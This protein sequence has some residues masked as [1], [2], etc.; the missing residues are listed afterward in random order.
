MPTTIETARAKIV[1]SS[2]EFFEL[3]HAPKPFVAG[4]SYIPV[5]VK[6]MDADATLRLQVRNVGNT[7]RWDI[8]AN[9][10]ALVTEEKRRF[11]LSLAADF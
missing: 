4:E 6:V 11:S 10:L 9:Q 3:S 1:E 2:R 5:T 7:C 8:N